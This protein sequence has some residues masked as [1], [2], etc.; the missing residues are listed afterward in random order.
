MIPSTNKIFDFYKC[1][2]TSLTGTW[3]YIYLITINLMVTVAAIPAE[4]QIADEKLWTSPADKNQ[5]E[6]VN[7]PAEFFKRYQPNTALDMIKQVPGFQLDDGSNLRGF[8]NAAGNIRI[9]NRRPSA[10]QDV[11]SAILRRIPANYVER[12]DLIRGQV[13][14]IDLQGQSVVANI[15]LHEDT[16]AAVRW[17]ALAQKNFYAPPLSSELSISLSDRWKDIDYNA[18]LSGRRSVTGFEG[19]ENVFNKN[20][21][22]TEERFDDYL[23]LGYEGGANLNASTSFD[24]T[25]VQLNTKLG[26]RTFDV[27]VSSLRVPTAGGAPRNEYF[28]QDQTFREFEVGVDAEREL[29]QNIF[30]KSIFLFYSQ[31]GDGSNA[32]RVV[33]TTGN[34]PLYFKKADTETAT[35]EVIGRMEFDWVGWIDRVLQANFEVAYNALDS[36]LI[37]IEDKGSGSMVVEVPGANT[38]VDE[39]RWDAQI[40]DTWSSGSFVLNYGL[41]LERSTISQSGV[42]GQ[43]RDFLY[44]KPHSLLTYSP[45]QMQQTRLRLAREVAQLNFNDFVSA[46]VFEDEDLALGNPDLRPETTWLAELTHERRFG[47]LAVATLTAFYHWIADVQDLLPLTSEFEVPGNIGKGS[48]WGLELEST[49]PLEW[50]GLRGARLDIKARWQHSSVMDLVTGENRVL[51]GKNTLGTAVAIPFRDDSDEYRYVYDIAYRQDF[52]ATQVAW[53][54]DIAD[55]AERILFKVNELDRIDERGLEFNAFVETTRWG[56]IKT[57]IEAENILNLAEGRNRTIYTGERNLSD[58]ARQEIRD[59]AKGH[60]LTLLFSGSF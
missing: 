4:A 35:K 54:W 34:Q 56:G 26:S 53:G 40:Q 7:Y 44:L 37:Q 33:E 9:N 60:R 45:S 21:S 43:E 6:V 31:L 27:A 19:T 38:R 18:G 46:S 57:R 16:P 52:I 50:L 5:E 2:V 3:F 58:V 13:E 39:I 12:I 49:V 32:Q 42:D 55:R 24:E 29:S 20:G 59:R 15:I 8:G 36:N 30:A 1:L 48:R 10:K 47:E 25:F 11:L 22:L 23:R 17:E 41:G 14:G 51:S 28:N